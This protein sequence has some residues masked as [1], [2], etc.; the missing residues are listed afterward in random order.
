MEED[1]LMIQVVYQCSV[2]NY[3]VS[4]YLIMDFNYVLVR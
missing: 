2:G 4:M 3:V 1:G